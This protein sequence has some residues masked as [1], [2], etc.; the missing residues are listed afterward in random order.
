MWVVELGQGPASESWA[1]Q[2]TP[3]AE[4]PG[5]SNIRKFY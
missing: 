4:P 5:K 1:G 3:G 2:K